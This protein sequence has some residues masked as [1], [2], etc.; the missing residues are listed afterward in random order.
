MLTKNITTDEFKFLDDTGSFRAVF[1]TFDFNEPDKHGDITLPGA[2]TDGEKVKIAAWGHNWGALP[3]GK[4]VIYSDN[5]KAWV[6]G[7]FF[8]STSHGRDAYETIKGLAD[9]NEFSYGFD[10]I[11][12]E[13]IDGHRVLKKL[14]VYEVS[15]VLVGAGNHTGLETIKSYRYQGAKALLL[16]LQ[17]LKH[18]GRDYQLLNEIRQLKTN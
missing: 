9:L 4:G 11:D 10:V 7:Q 5:Y 6:D 12:S 1:S 8:I 14:K 17:A 2:F 13:I 16:E 18:Q 15:P 3:V